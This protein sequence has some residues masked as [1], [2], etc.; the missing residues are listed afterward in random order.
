MTRTARTT[1]GACAAALLLQSGASAQQPA[2]AA[3][4]GALTAEERAIAGAV[5]G[6]HAQ[7][8]A[9]RLAR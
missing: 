3:G 2:G 4:R 9:L 7:A 6:E 8:R 1:L 5:D